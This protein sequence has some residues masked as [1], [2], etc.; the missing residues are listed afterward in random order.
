MQKTWDE[1][2]DIWSM[3]NVYY[4]ILKGSTFMNIYEPLLCLRYITFT[5]GYLQFE[6]PPL[7]FLSYYW[8]KDKFYHRESASSLLK[9]EPNE[10]I[11]ASMI[12]LPSLRKS[13][14]EIVKLFN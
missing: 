14:S 13:A 11:D 8:N 5:Y 12:P 7:P 10:V 3:G 6:N 4:Y 2:I 1:K 9:L